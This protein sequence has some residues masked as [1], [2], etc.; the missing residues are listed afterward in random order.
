MKPFQVT[1]FGGAQP[2]PGEPVYEQALQL[3]KLLG[4]QGW[5]VL[6]GGYIGTMEAVSRGAAEAGSHVIGI[7]CADIEIYRPVKANQWVAEE[8]KYPTLRERLL[9]LIDKCDAAVALPGGVGTLTEIL[10][11]WNQLLIHT[12]SPRPLILIGSGWKNIVNTLFTEMDP[13]IP[14]SQRHWV[15]FAVDHNQAVSMLQEFTRSGKV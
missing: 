7:T 11:T 10:M 1:V 13:H 14:D 4:N 9:A 12:I 5:T 2:K 3:G 6:T 8:I 15:Y